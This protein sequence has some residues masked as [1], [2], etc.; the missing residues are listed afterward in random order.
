MSTVYNSWTDRP[1]QVSNDYYRDET[2]K[3]A[4]KKVLCWCYIH[5]HLLFTF[6][7]CMAKRE[8][9]KLFKVLNAKSLLNANITLSGH[10]LLHLKERVDLS[11]SR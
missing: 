10:G 4:F 5:K 9:N 3:Y 2:K 7:N 8:Y 6:R 1:V 11:L